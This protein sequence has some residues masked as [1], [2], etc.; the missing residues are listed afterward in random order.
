MNKIIFAAQVFGLIAMF[1]VVVILEINHVTG[2][3][4]KSNPTP[5]I[6]KQTEIKGFRLQEKEKDKMEK[7]VFPVSL[8]TVL[9]FKNF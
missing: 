2:S 6:N 1:P 7:E 4:C 5:C 8:E 3:S 9:L